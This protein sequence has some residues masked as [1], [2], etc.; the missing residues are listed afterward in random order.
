M[1]DISKFQVSY[2]PANDFSCP[3]A[4]CDAIATDPQYL[5]SIQQSSILINYLN[6]Y[7]IIDTKRLLL[8]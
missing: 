5:K 3:V 2:E 7:S 1:E 4:A 6:A 8:I